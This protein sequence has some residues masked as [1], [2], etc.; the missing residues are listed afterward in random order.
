MSEKKVHKRIKGTGE[1]PFEDEAIWCHLGSIERD[2][3]ATDDWLKVTCQHCVNA[4]KRHEK[5]IASLP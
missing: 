3:E 5:Q 2:Y 1:H 4:K